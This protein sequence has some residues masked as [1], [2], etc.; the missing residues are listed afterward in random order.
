MGA[1]EELFGVPEGHTLK[2]TSFRSSRGEQSE[3]WRY[4]EYDAEGKLVATYSKWIESSI[5]GKFESGGW[6]KHDLNGKQVASGT[7]E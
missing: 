7:L 5:Y 6:S 4:E 1:N 2:Q 3:S